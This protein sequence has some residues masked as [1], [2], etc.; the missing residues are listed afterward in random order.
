MFFLLPFP[1]RL[2]DSLHGNVH[3]TADTFPGFL[4]APLSV[5]LADHLCRLV[6]TAA[7]FAIL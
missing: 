2:K 6:V 1:P 3:G 5:N 4:L 7:A